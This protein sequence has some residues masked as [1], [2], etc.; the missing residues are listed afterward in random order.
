MRTWARPQAG[1]CDRQVW[2]SGLKAQANF[3]ES[4]RFTP[5]DGNEVATILVHRLFGGRGCGVSA[6]AHTSTSTA[7]RRRWRG[8]MSG[9]GPLP[10]HPE[11]RLRCIGDMRQGCLARASNIAGNEKFHQ[12]GKFGDAFSSAAFVLQRRGLWQLRNGRRLR[13]WPS[14]LVLS[15]RHT[16]V[17]SAGE[18]RHGFQQAPLRTG[19]EGTP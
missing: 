11:W 8:V 4:G 2:S 15:S 7:K 14:L 6:W 13:S 1:I 16:L 19:A 18:P 12:R 10:Q 3:H 5:D 9:C 17:H